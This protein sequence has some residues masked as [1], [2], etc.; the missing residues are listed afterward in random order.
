MHGVYKYEYDGR[1]VYVGKT[2]NS[3]ESRIYIHSRD[4]KF[5]PYLDE[6]SIF[7]YETRD[8][9]E[10]DFLETVLISQHKPILNEAKHQTTSVNVCADIQWI[11]WSGGWK[12]K[13]SPDEHRSIKGYSFTLKVETVN[14]LKALAKSRGVSTSKMM[15]IILSEVL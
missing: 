2:S 15:D 7:I 4:E 12:Q 1:V 11:P 9:R 13:R 14:K 8:E 3:F 5:K 10:A 6:A